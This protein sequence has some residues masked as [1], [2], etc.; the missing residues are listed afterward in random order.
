MTAGGMGHDEIIA[1]GIGDD[2]ITG[3]DGLG[4]AVFTGFR[5]TLRLR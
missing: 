2:T 4:V 3:G 1:G 5:T